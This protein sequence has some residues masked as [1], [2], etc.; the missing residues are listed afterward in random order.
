MPVEPVC[1]M[2]A[3]D[4][5]EITADFE[6][7]TFYF[8]SSD[9]RDFFEEHPKRFVDEPRPHLC[10]ASGVMVPRLHYGRAVGEFNLTVADPELLSV[11]L[12][13]D[14]DLQF[15]LERANKAAERS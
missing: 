13:D 9:C 15:D 3:S 8:C 7:T 6:G 1:G 12:E 11:G 14:T 10:D 4:S 2:E 5:S